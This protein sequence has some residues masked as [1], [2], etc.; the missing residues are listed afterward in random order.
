MHDRFEVRPVGYAH[1]NV[2]SELLVTIR[3]VLQPRRNKLRIRHNDGNVVQSPDRR[4]A[5][6][7][8]D[9]VSLLITYHD[10]VSN[11]DRSL[12]KQD[13]AGN[14]VGSDVLQSKAN[15]DR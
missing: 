14:E 7:D 3:P 5:H 12:E 4:R 10:P 6:F 15:A 2:H 11:L 1:I 13:K 9:D 8:F